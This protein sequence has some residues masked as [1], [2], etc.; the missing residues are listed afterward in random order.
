MS[1]VS[2]CVPT[3]ENAEGVK[4]LIDSILMQSY[5]DLEIIISDDSKTDIIE[6]I[7]QEYEDDR[8]KYFRHVNEGS[9]TANWNNAIR[10]SKG[11]YIK[12]MHHDDWFTT[13]TALNEFVKML[14]DNPQAVLAFSG[15]RQVGQKV[16]DRCMNEEQEDCLRKDYRYVFCHNKIGAPSATIFRNDGKCFDEKLKWLVDSEFY[17]RILET[18]KQFVFTREPLVSIGIADTQVTNSCINNKCLL[19]RE[20]TYVYSKLGLSKSKMCKKKLYTVLYEQGA[21]WSDCKKYGI[22]SV[23]YVFYRLLKNIKNKLKE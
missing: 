13:E 21:D 18:D 1:K 10:K 17:M 19:L 3:Y 7:V 2:I 9:S 22:D 12:V 6:T 20:Y 11:E 23:S 5:K 4:R 15:S 14:E 16:Y 8:I